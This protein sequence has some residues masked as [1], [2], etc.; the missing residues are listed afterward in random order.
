MIK[1]MRSIIAG[2]LLV[3]GMIVC[4]SGCSSE[5]NGSGGSTN[6]DS[7][8]EQKNETITLTARSSSSNGESFVDITIAFSNYSSNPASVDVYAEGRTAAIQTGVAV[9]DGKISFSVSALS[10]GTYNIYVKC[11]NV[12]SNSIP[13]T[14]AKKSEK[15]IISVGNAD[16][17]QKPA[18]AVIHFKQS[19]D[20]SKYDFGEKET[21]NVPAGSTVASLA[22]DYKGFTAQGLFLAEQTD[23]SYVVHIYYTRDIISVTLDA[24][25]GTIGDAATFVVKGL[26][27]A[28]LPLGKNLSVAHEVKVFGG[29]NTKADGTGTDYEDGAVIDSTSMTLYAK[30]LDYYEVTVA[31]APSKIESLASGS[32]TVKVTGY[33]TSYDIAAINT[34]LLKDTKRY[35]A[36]DLSETTGLTALGKEAFTSTVNY[37]HIGA[38]LSALILPSSVTSIG[39]YCF[40]YCQQLTSVVAPGV[41]VLNTGAFYVCSKLTEIVLHD[42]MDSIGDLAFGFCSS[43]TEMTLNAKTLGSNIFCADEKLTSITIGK[44]VETISNEGFISSSSTPGLLANISVASEN[45]HFKVQNGILYSYDGT[46]LIRCLPTSE[47]TTITVDSSV[48]AMDAYAFAECKNLKTITISNVLSIPNSILLICPN[49]ETVTIQNATSIG[50]M[51][52]YRCEKLTSVTLPDTLT[53]IGGDTFSYDKALSSIFIPAS[54]TTMASEVFEY[55]TSDQTINCAASSKPEGWDAK[56]DYYN[57]STPAKATINWGATRN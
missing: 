11:G 32:Y 42:T 46:R 37:D 2:I 21:K 23:G 47:L 41:T 16:G 29:W 39:E 53:K 45:T 30:W 38:P 25:G 36:L 28:A 27:G 24:N 17:T 35:I 33:I 8:V 40:Y 34:A 57:Y 6:P 43:L 22:K 4:F 44:D 7:V 12:T 31:E 55:W 5:L 51:A 54:V 1:K 9:S 19:V 52:F 48:T 18:S 10:E 26:Y 20:G 3:T 13:I 56:W 14:I 49:L 15:I 50:Y